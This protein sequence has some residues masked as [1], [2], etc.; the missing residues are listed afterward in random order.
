MQ[1][2][3]NDGQWR[4]A[5]TIW[6]VVNCVNVLQTV[7]FLSRVPSGSMVVNHLLGYV[8]VA[9][10]IP[11]VIALIAFFRSRA[12]WRQWIGPAVFLAFVLFMAVVDYVW[13]VEF[14]SPPRPAILAPY[15]T[16]F[17]GSILLM[18]IPMYRLNRKLWAVTAGTT[19]L[20]LGSMGIAM[21]N[22][23]G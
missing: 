21:V 13:Q 2:Q 12:S 5:L 10:A 4:A 8:I 20:L 11:S 19:V 6:G 22:G 1:A 15:L 23:V 18:G 7:G 14:R 16:L 17:F 3:T 9:L